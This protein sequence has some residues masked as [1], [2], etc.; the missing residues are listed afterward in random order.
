M[1]NLIISTDK[2]IAAS[3]ARIKFGQLLEAVS[4]DKKNYFV[5]LQ[6]GKL[7]ALLVHPQWL[8][9]KSGSDFPDLEKIRTDWNRHEEDLQKG[10]EKIHSMDK[11]ALPPLLQ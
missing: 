9:E 11:K 5:I 2:L 4:S 1:H 7:A 10:L 6:N 8:K 3:E